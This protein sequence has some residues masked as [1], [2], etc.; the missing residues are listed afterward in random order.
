[1]ARAPL[2]AREGR[3]RLADRGRSRD[4]AGH[5]LQLAESGTLLVRA[6]DADW[7]REVAGAF[8]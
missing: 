3:V 2:D 6:A 4:G 8:P 1:M 5:A 7:R